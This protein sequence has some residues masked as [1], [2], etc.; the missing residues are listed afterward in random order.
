MVN[1]ASNNFWP[2]SEYSKFLETNKFVW[3]YQLIGKPGNPI[4][5]LIHGAGASSHSFANLIPKLQNFQVLAVDLPGHRFSKIKKGIRPQHDIIVRDL[6]IL[7]E[8]LKI[9]PNVF[10]GHSIGAV[11]V[12]SLSDIYEGPLSSIVLI[13]GALERFEGP[14]ATIF[15]LMARVFYASPLTKYWIRLFNSAETSLRKFLSISGSNLTVKNI[16]YYMKLMTDEDH[17][18]GTLAF[19]SN[20]NIGDIE[21]KLKKVSVPTLFLAGMRDGIV[22]YKTSVRAHKKAFNAKIKL[23]ESEGH[24]IHEVSSAKVAKEINFLRPKSD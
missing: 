13:N 7:F 4:I 1:D 2:Y 10:V 6:I 14:A 22:N 15:P 20:W 5:L 19:I 23:F 8:S 24:L 21:K 11:I 17:V 12:L 18:T 9:K 3:H 16:D